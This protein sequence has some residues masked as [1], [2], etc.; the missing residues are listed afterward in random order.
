[1]TA[2]TKALVYWWEEYYDELVAAKQHSLWAKIK[3][4]IAELGN[5][6]SLKQIKDK[7]RNL[8]DTYKQVRENNKQTGKLPIFCPFYEDFDGIFGAR[9]TVNLPYAK[10][11]GVVASSHHISDAASGEATPSTNEGLILFNFYLG[12]VLKLRLNS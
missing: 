12:W 2:Q 8:K 4:E 6:K 5:P 9:D 1:M 7:L 3:V 10:E 11:A